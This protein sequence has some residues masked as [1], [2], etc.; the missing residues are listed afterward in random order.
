MTWVIIL[1]PPSP[2]PVYLVAAAILG[3]IVSYF[4][5]YFAARR[6]AHQPVDQ[7]VDDERAALYA[8]ALSPADVFKVT[9]ALRPEDFTNPEL[10]ERYKAFT[11][12]VL[13]T[14]AA[15]KPTL[16]LEKATRKAKKAVK[17]ATAAAN[18][19]PLT[20]ELR[21]KYAYAPGDIPKF[22]PK[23]KDQVLYYCGAVMS[24]GAFRELGT[25]RS[26]IVN[27]NGTLSRA[28]AAPSRSRLVLS[29]LAG[30]AAT[31]LLTIATQHIMLTSPPQLLAIAATLV[32][33][34]T[35]IS[36]SCT[37]F[38]TY[39]LDTKSFW[40]LTALAWG[41]TALAQVYNHSPHRLLAGV[42]VVI[43]VAVLYESIAIGSSI[44]R[45]V[46]QGVGD[47]MIILLTIGV[48][49]ALTGSWQIG[50]YS[51][52]LGGFSGIIEWVYRH[53]T[54]D[55]SRKTPVAFGPHLCV[56]WVLACAALLIVGIL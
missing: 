51:S 17:A 32:L 54:K 47:T 33:V 25:S 41:L 22:D 30:A 23:K 48:T 45:G 38:D 6:T 13:A 39:Y 28:Y 10:A 36:L 49:G 3:A 18:N 19:D 16:D 9:P 8:L 52:I 46:R 7:D 2:T 53:R 43:F 37:D 55:A 20:E 5:V 42:T 11:E 35:C 31:L 44:L 24:A 14:L 27:N 21:V 15:Y 26:P 40:P 29:C 12:D 50:L 1:P 34:F 56:G 4:A